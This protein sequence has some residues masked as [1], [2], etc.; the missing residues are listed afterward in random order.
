MSKTSRVS[1]SSRTVRRSG[2]Q[3]ASLSHIDRIVVQDVQSRII[4]LVNRKSSWEGTITQ[5]RSALTTGIRRSVSSSFPTNPSYL[6]RVVNATLP[7]LR[8]NGVRVTFRRTTD[9]ARTRLVSFV[10]A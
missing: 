7:T 4:T 6:R 8:R 1:K 9:H 5:L 2:A 10:A 3:A